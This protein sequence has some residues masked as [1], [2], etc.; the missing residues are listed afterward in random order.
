MTNHLATEWFDGQ[1]PAARPVWAQ[2]AGGQLTLYPRGDEVRAQA[3]AD[4]A[5]IGT[6]P[7]RQVRWPEAHAGGQ[8]QALLPGGGTLVGRDAA[9]WDA[10]RQRQGARTGLAERAS[11]NWGIALGVLLAT[12]AVLAVLWRWGVPVAADQAAHWVPARL[13]QQLGDV[14]LAQMQGDWLEPSQLSEA[15]RQALAARFARTAARAAQPA[16]T[17]QLHVARG[18][19]RVGANAFALP[20]GHVVVTD[21]LVEL[22]R[23]QPD[24]LQGVLAHELGHVHHGH[25]LR[26]VA[27]ASAV[28]AIVSLAVGDASWLFTAV[29]TLLVQMDYSRDFEREADAYALALMQ[30]GGLDARQMAVFFDRLT[31][32]RD[33]EGAGE[34]PI[35]FSSHPA[36][37]ERRA[38][39][40]H[41]AKAIAGAGAD[42]DAVSTR[43]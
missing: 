22:L 4:I 31:E 1:T 26:M 39:F 8:R 12:V 33:Q 43:R 42:V 6:W 16:P 30:R 13:Q 2:V 7:V 25:A 41:G 15:E 19:E 18:S 34:L 27:R 40:L 38:F 5:A 28:A 11:R 10:W 35:G 36:D 9:A 14:T 3:G 23:D 29:P 21:Q 24:A 17:Y 32:L 20:G 37:S